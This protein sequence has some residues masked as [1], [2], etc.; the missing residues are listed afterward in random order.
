MPL[1]QR[2]CS[3]PQPAWIP[4]GNGKRSHCGDV[5]RCAVLLLLVFA[6]LGCRS[7][8]FKPTNLPD[9]L[10]ARP[11][12]S[13]TQLNLAGLDGGA[14]NVN[15]IYP[16][17]VLQV[18]VVTG[19]ER[20][21]DT[22]WRLRVDER[23]AIHLPQ[24]GPV[25][26]AGLELVAAE[27]LIGEVYRRRQIYLHPSVSLTVE[28]RRT[29]QITVEGA[30]A[31]PGSYDL[32][33]SNAD[34]TAALL[35]AGGL[36]DEADTIVQVRQ[37]HTRQANPQSLDSEPT[38]NEARQAGFEQ[39]QTS[40]VD[41]RHID[42]ATIDSDDQPAM[43]LDDGALVTVTRRPV[44]TVGVVGLVKSS[45]QLPYPI[46]KELRL[47]DA[48]TAAGGT[49]TELANK[50]FVVRRMP[51]SEET[52]IIKTSIAKAKRDLDW[53]VLLS[54]GDVVSVEETPQTFV[55]R[56]LRNILNT[57]LLGVRLYTFPF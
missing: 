41:V 24:V 28:A 8:V 51:D 47:L 32:P 4:D 10:V 19:A 13:A 34:L 46:G 5:Y 45:K 43:L 39:P 29:R 7:G 11:V 22:N 27:R 6:G 25:Q 26:V 30:V 1:S 55:W 42:L 54:P 56:G 35:A 52:V 15:A 17:D 44:P 14:I 21:D 49:N 3:N 40:H 37:V 36:T 20:R 33:A 31:K 18:A 50:V 16:G 12:V 2:R 23:G 53:N 57:A 48:I 9:N 38:A